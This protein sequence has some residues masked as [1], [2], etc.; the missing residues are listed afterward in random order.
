[1]RKTFP[2]KV[3]TQAQSLKFVKRMLAVTVSNITYVW[4]MFPEKAYAIQFGGGLM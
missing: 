1:M 4:S 3:D 2:V